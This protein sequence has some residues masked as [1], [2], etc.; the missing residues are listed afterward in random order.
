MCMEKIRME[1]RTHLVCL[2][3]SPTEI[4][5]SLTAMETSFQ[6]H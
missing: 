2:T 6:Y 1:G 5:P 4:G 3:G